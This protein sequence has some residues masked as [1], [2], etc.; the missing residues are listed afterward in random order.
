[1]EAVANNLANVDTTGYKQD[2][3]A[4]EM[5][6]ARSMA[7]PSTSDEE[8]FFHGQHI[9][10]YTRVGTH[11]VSVADMGKDF[12]QGRLMNT[13]RVF[14]LAMGQEQGFFTLSTPQGERYTRAGN[15]HLNAE[16]QLSSPQGH[17]VLG[18]DGEPIVIEGKEVAFNEDGSIVVD[19]QVIGGLKVVE[20]DSP[21][22]LQ[23][24]GSNLFAPIAPEHSARIL[25]E[26]SVQQGYLESSNVDSFKEMVRMIEANRAYSSMQRALT[27]ND[28][29]NENAI[30]LGKV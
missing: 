1:M 5:V 4:F 30:S 27:V 15:F 16:N 13:G 28:R 10:P 6:F 18:K 9:P 11:F 12:N 24:L 17:L 3:P 21:E 2:Q 29:M 7:V 22:Q 19:G 14:D 23:K 25:E 20:F 26:T 8:Q